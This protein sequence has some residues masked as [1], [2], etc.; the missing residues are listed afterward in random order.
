MTRIT[1]PLARSFYALAVAAA[2][3]FGAAEAL[4]APRDARETAAARPYCDPVE[5]N[6]RC[7]GYGMCTGAFTCLCY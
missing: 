3:A 1:R 5:C 4:A 2:L 7:G 6:A